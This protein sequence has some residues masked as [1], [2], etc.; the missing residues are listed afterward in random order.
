MR[1][2][3]L[4]DLLD[5]YA[6]DL[7]NRIF[8]FDLPKGK[9][10]QVRFYEE[11]FC[12]L[13]GIQHIFNNKRYLGKAGFERIKNEKLIMKDVINASGKKSKEII[14][15]LEHFT[16]ILKILQE[17]ELVIFDSEKVKHPT[18]IQADFCLYDDNKLYIAHLFLR[19]ST[20]LKEEYA[21]ISFIV[22]EYSDK[23]YKSFIENQKYI[24]I[25]NRRIVETGNSM[26]KIQV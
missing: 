6:S 24:K 1:E 10:I 18:D 13:L 19:K 15:R 14:K 3:V 26:Y 2:V 21:P 4:K 9:T 12:H 23:K 5:F 7:C 16:D 20:A 25:V 8:E 22:R 17:G 11:Q